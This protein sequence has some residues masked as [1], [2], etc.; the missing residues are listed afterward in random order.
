[1]VPWQFI[2]TLGLGIVTAV[3]TL[4][5]LVDWAMVHH[6][7][8]LF[9]LFMGLVLGSAVAILPRIKG[10][11]VSKVIALV[12]GAAFAYFLVG[13]VPQENV[14][15]DPVTLFFSGMAAITAMILPGISGS[16]ILLVLGQY[17]HAL[18]AVKTLDIVSLVSLAA[19]CAVGIMTFARILSWLLKRFE[20]MTVA[21]LI[22]F[23]IGSLR[24]VWP[25]KLATFDPTTEEAVVRA[26]SAN[27][28]PD[29]SSPDFVGSLLLIVVGFV[30]VNLLDHVASGENPVFRSF[31]RRPASLAVGD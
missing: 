23:V 28:M 10:W 5:H 18:N 31:W 13:A 14:P 8:Y 6:R 21:V 25:W 16:S 15:H 2:V 12:L 9:A 30:I 22:G 29:P 3:L 17:Q 7:V 19:G 1:Y 27:V 24:A 20:Q 26:A 11:T 4:A